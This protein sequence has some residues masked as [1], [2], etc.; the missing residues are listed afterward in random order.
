MV[1]MGASDAAYG[2]IKQRVPQRW[3]TCGAS[4]SRA[5]LAFS[6]GI[7]YAD[8]E[9]AKVISLDKERDSR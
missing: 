7:G 5:A 1:P 8:R 4:G 6:D 3:T 2:I 9:N